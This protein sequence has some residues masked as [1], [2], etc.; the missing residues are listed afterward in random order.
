VYSRDTGRGNSREAGWS[1]GGRGLSTEQR[2]R[3]VRSKAVSSG[4]P[5]APEC[6]CGANAVRPSPT[7][8]QK[9]RTRAAGPEGAEH[10]RRLLVEERLD[11]CHVASVQARDGGDGLAHR[12]EL[13]A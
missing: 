11:D 8:L 3:T 13:C 1:G 9:R 4:R 7:T 12:E 5:L 6:N 10:L 2:R